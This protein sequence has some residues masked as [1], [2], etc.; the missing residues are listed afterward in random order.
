MK[1]STFAVLATLFGLGAAQCARDNCLRAIVASNIATRS[2]SA[3]CASFLQT[4]VYPGASTTTATVT[5][6]TSGKRQSPATSVS[7]AFP[8]YASACRSVARYVSA[9]SCVGVTPTTVTSSAAVV[10]VTASV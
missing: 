9:C 4:T 6:P 2:G 7:S 3:D 1:S 10:T 5:V 8:A